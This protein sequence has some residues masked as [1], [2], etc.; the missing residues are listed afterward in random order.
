[1]HIELSD[2]TA[3]FKERD[4][5]ALDG[6]SLTIE[7]GEH[8]ALLG[9]SGSGKTTLLRCLLG[10]VRPLSGT[11]RVDGLDPTEPR[12]LR[13]IRRS[14]GVIRQG[15]DL[16]LA[17]RAQTNA[18]LGTAPG[19]TAADW[20][21][22]LRGRVPARF[23]DQV[24]RL[25]ERQGI[26]PFLKSRAEHLSGGQRQR[27]ALVRAVLP[28]P[29]LLLADEPTSGLDPVTARAAVQALREATGVTVVVSTHDLA[30]ARRF[31]RIVALRQGRIC[32][33]GDH[34][35]EADADAI[36]DERVVSA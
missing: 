11:A 9:P 17:L 31:P 26:L 21:T 30:I 28:Q 8:V 18:V 23:R 29:R 16:I 3:A 2:I 27:V 15:N 12:D 24:S 14:S 1:M 10:A 20:V 19:W 13:R 5:P 34:L 4:D 35:S 25:A 36:Y 22:I 7:R 6:V 33:D 32:F